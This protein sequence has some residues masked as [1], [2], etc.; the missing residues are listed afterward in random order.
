M[1]NASTTAAPPSRAGWTD[2]QG[3][4]LSYLRLAVTDRCNLRC[5]Y[6]MPAAGV[7]LRPP[8]SQLTFD[9]LTRLCRIMVRGGIR[10][11]RVTGGEPLA[12]R[13]VVEWMQSIA[14]LDPAPEI[15]LTTNGVLLA[16][17]LPRLVSGGLRRVNLSLDTLDPATWR[18]ITRRGGFEAARDSIDAVLDAGLGLK[19]NVV[20]QPGVND[21]EIADFVA[22]TR[23]R[24]V[25][26]RFIEPMPFTGSGTTALPLVSGDW[27]LRRVRARFAT[28]E[29][30][31]SPGD[32]ERRFRIAGHRGTV[33]VI[34]GNGRGFCGDCCRLRLN[35]RGELRTCL[36]GIPAADLGTALRDGA[37]DSELVSLIEDA[38]SRR[39]PD[40][41]IA[42]AARG[43]AVSMAEVGG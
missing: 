20:V 15:L 22:L 34:E 10:K 26:V 28:E 30:P 41:H 25:R 23:E 42:E 40:G 39:V 17:A 32:V 3:R 9:E 21:H 14:R 7:A 31:R 5:R 1:N 8:G 43:S 29:L 36:Y 27:I 12:R 2:P 13:G 37:G 24:E 18:T 4:P 38:I 6:C 35:S 16:D 33:G 19:I 11:V